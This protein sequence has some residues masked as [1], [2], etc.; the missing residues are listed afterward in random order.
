MIQ[1]KCCVCSEDY[2]CTPCTENI[3]W[4]C[5]TVNGDE[6]AL[7]CDSCLDQMAEEFLGFEAGG[8][9]SEFSVVWV[10]EDES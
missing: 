4:A 1:H 10:P 8:Q 7:T 9:S 3:K 5:S 2:D 6:D